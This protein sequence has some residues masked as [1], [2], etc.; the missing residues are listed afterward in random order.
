MTKAS[1]RFLWFEFLKVIFDFNFFTVSHKEMISF[2]SQ[3]N[4]TIRPVKT[5]SN[6]NW[7]KLMNGLCAVLKQKIDIP[8]DFGFELVPSTKTRAPKWTIYNSTKIKSNFSTSQCGR[9][10][11]L[12]GQDLQQWTSGLVGVIVHCLRDCY[13][14]SKNIL[15]YSNNLSWMFL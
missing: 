15:K 4:F 8:S 12:A 2:L 11:L 6:L 10:L 13:K 1:I 7:L 9:P 5:N 14:E 3:S